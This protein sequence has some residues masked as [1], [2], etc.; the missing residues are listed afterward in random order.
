MICCEL[1]RFVRFPGSELK[2]RS[3]ASLKNHFLYLC[4]NNIIYIKFP[5][6][7]LFC[8]YEAPEQRYPHSYVSRP[9]LARHYWNTS[10][11]RLH[12]RHCPPLVLPIKTHLLLFL[13]ILLCS[14]RRPAPNCGKS[15]PSL[16]SAASSTGRRG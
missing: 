15:R 12:L 4:H 5:H 3:D 1:G 2:V 6:L 8:R 9:A 14:S 10:R 11:C 13:F 7:S 16:P